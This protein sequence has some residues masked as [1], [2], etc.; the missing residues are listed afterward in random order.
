MGRQIQTL[1]GI[2]HRNDGVRCAIAGEIRRRDEH[3]RGA[4]GGPLDVEATKRE[5]WLHVH[6]GHRARPGGSH[7]VRLRDA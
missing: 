5:G 7:E 3:G 1:V 2:E 6:A 4:E